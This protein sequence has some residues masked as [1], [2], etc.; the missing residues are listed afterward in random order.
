MSSSLK[1]GSILSVDSG[2]TATIEIDS[3]L[4]LNIIS[5]IFENGMKNA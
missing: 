1:L 2:D 5:L 3:G 4:M